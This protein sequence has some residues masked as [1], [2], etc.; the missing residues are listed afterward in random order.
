M[1]TCS[2]CNTPG[3]REKSGFQS[4]QSKCR[5]CR[6]EVERSNRG[7]VGPS[8]AERDL[9]REREEKLEAERDRRAQAR[10]VD[11]LR[12][13][14][15][16]QSFIDQITGARLTAKIPAREKGTLREMTAVA[17]ASDWHVEETVDPEAVA[18]RNKYDLTV[19]ADRVERFFQA[20]AWNV[21][22]QRGSGKVV[23]RDLVLWLGGDLISGY[24]H[25]ELQEGNELSPTQAILWLMPRLEGGIRGLLDRLGLD[26]IVVPCSFGNHGRTTHRKRISTGHANSYEWLMYKDL[27]AR[28]RDEKRVRFEVT[29]S[30]HQY[31]QVYDRVIHFHHGDSLN[32]QGGVGGIGIPL[33]KAVPQW[34]RVIRADVHCIG[35]F[36]Q[37]RDFGRAVVNGSLIGFS[38]YAQE[39]RAE[40]EEPQQALFFIDSKRGKTM[41]SPLWVAERSV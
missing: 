40:Y 12:E 1:K 11:E 8:K 4:G 33:L 24:I 31:V 13:L 7:T 28:M 34:D 15:L 38:P 21:E 6:A 3:G 5:V 10:V 26:S 23:V 20:V 39:I 9:V 29:A 32:Y 27:E 14:R 17:L 2:M 25:E 36:H 22:H 41:N 18:G 19:A 35:H 16:R 30:A 37:Y